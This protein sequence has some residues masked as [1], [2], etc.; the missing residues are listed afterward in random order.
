MYTYDCGDSWEHI[1]KLEKILKDSTL[2]T[3]D[4]IDGKGT[5]PPED[6][7]GPWGYTELKETLADPKSPEHADMKEWLGLG[8]KQKWNADGFKL[9][10]VAAQVRT[11]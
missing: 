1:I 5:C 4:C 8:K 9:K 3:A 10:D 7:G 11:I 2:Q 6:C